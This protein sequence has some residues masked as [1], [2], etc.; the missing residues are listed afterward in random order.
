[1]ASKIISRIFNRSIEN[2]ESSSF[3]EDNK[4]DESFATFYFEKVD[5]NSEEKINHASDK[6]ECYYSKQMQEESYS[7]RERSVFED[8]EKEKKF[9][10]V[11]T[12]ID[13]P[14]RTFSANLFCT[15]DLVNR[16]VLFSF[17]DLSSKDRS[18]VEIGR[19]IIYIYGKQYRNGTVTNVSNLYFRNFS[20]WT[21]RE[22]ELK[23]IEANELYNLLN[24]N[25]LDNYD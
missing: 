22:I 19:R 6:T 13:Y 21:E 25:G 14:N 23:R 20:N 2:V 12:D 9:L 5:R 4:D 18:L 10:G 24:N 11:I 1:M 17:D 15:D 16:I 3:S 8:F 7:G